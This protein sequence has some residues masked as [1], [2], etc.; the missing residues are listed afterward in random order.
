MNAARQIAG[1][2]QL[3]LSRSLVEDGDDRKPLGDD[4]VVTLLVDHEGGRCFLRGHGRDLPSRHAPD[5][6]G[7]RIRA[8]VDPAPIYGAEG[9]SEA[10]PGYRLKSLG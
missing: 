8:V 7:R 9:G 1:T 5:L 4:E 10:R 6:E 2:V 3:V